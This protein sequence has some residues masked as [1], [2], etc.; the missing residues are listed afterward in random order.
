M[1]TLNAIVIKSKEGKNGKNKVRIS[2]AHN[3]ETRYIVTD[4][5]LNSSKEFKNGSVV[6]RPDAAILNTKIRKLLQH[7]QSVLDEL[8][9]IDGLTCSELIFQLKNANQRRHR[10]LKSIYEEYVNNAQIKAASAT[11]YQTCWNSISKQLGDNMLI[12]HINHYTILKLDKNLRSRG[13]SNDTIKNKIIFL[14]ILVKFAERCGYVHF[15]VNPFAGYKTPCKVIRDSW[16]SV[17]EI[18]RIRDL[19]TTRKNISKCRDLLM[20]SYYLGGINITDLI[21]INFN[22]QTDTIRY[23][24]KKT[25][26]VQKIN[27]YVEFRIPEEAKQIIGKWK[28][29]DGRL[30]ISEFQ[31]RMKLREFFSRNM[32]LLGELVGV[33]HL[34]YYSA[35]KSFS[36]HAFEL[37]INTSV[38]DYILG[39]S[40]GKGGSSLY[41]YVFVTPG[42]A[43]E[44]VRKVLDNLK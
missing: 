9:Y 38:I 40:I 18:R 3:G 24:R 36:Q 23:E 19:K 37:G 25:D 6:K 35:R 8:Q 41:H 32:K 27:K 7:Y 29:V 15:N 31:R 34:I 33:K 30:K 43:T 44:A 10:T 11:Y 39:H 22:E 1:A 20:L 16:L 13:F 12:E 5:V 2:V 42:K 14:K 21:D 4:I 26:T 17:E 28:G